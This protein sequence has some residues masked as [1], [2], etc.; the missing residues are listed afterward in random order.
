MKKIKS[1]I[2]LILIAFVLVGCSGKTEEKKT[3][4]KSIDV[5]IYDTKEELVFEKNIEAKE[6]N[7]LKILKNDKELNILS[8]TSQYGEFI[9]SIRNITHPNNYFWNYYINDEYANVG[10][11][12]YTVKDKDKIEFRLE[13][14]E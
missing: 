7:L 10:V 3:A 12:S 5:L 11:D 8:E 14:F 9:T 4:M 13:K 1:L 2:L 6:D